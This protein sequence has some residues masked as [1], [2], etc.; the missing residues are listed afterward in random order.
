MADAGLKLAV[1]G[2]REFKKAIQEINAQI[3]ANQAEL[4]LLAEQYKHSDDSMGKLTST[5]KALEEAMTLQG[6]KVST[7]REQYEKAAEAYGENDIRVVKLKT[8]LTEA[9]AEYAK[10]TNEVAANQKAIDDNQSAL[11]EYQKTAEEIDD[12]MK[13]NRQELS[14]LADQYKALGDNSKSTAE[15]QE[16]LA[17]QNKLLTDNVENQKKKLED[18]NKKLELAKKLYGENSSEVDKWGDLVDHATKELEE[19]QEQIKKNEEELSDSGDAGAGLLDVLQ[20]IS[21]QT[22]IDIPEGIKKMI[23]SEGAGGFLGA[24]TAAGAIGTVLIG[25]AEK[26]IEITKETAEWADEVTTKSQEMDLGTEQYQ[27]LEY[28]VGKCG[29][30][31]ETLEDGMKELTNKVASSDNVLGDYIG[32]MEDLRYATDEEKKAVAEQMKFWDD[33]GI[34]IY[35]TATGKLKPT[36]ELFYELIEIF[37]NITDSGEKAYKMNEVFGESWKKLNPLVETGGDHLRKLAQEAYDLGVVMDEETVKALDRTDQKFYELNKTMDAAKRD[38]IPNMIQGF[39][40][41]WTVLSGGTV[42]NSDKGLAAWLKGIREDIE[43]LFGGG[44]AGTSNHI[45]GYATGTYNH[46]GG[47][48]LVGEKGPEI[49]SLPQGARVYPNGT[50]PEL[51]ASVNNYKITISASSI[52]E[53]NDVIRVMQSAQQTMRMR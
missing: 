6:N 10:L 26:I 49:V 38:F 29:V 11:E 44:Y 14:G 16:N 8:S 42:N 47:Y 4:K 51:G 43:V 3:K 30:S 19:M 20:K 28:A 23:G 41:I 21:D 35:D 1:E 18:L 34:S 27:A 33:L 46:I 31:M 2:E 50:G 9:T 40:D 36:E 32:N 12:V 22:G 48:A 25:V 15:K 7:L 5:Q 24:A 13:A 53:F 45:R 52:R 17:K 37:S 39:K